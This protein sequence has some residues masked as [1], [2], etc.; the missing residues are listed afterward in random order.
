MDLY[1][2]KHVLENAPPAVGDDIEGG[3]WLQAN[4]LPDTSMNNETRH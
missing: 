2:A 3:F 4:V 1:V